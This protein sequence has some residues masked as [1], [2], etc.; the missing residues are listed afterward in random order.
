MF[1]TSFVEEHGVAARSQTS[2]VTSSGLAAKS[3][4]SGFPSSAAS[5]HSGEEDENVEEDQVFCKP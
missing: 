3:V 5:F 4:D 1:I 2:T